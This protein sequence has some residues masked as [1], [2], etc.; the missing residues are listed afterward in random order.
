MIKI[1]VI[2]VT[3]AILAAW[4]KNV[5]SEYA[6]WIVLAAGVFLVLS[7]LLKLDAIID[8][9]RF[10]QGY[11]SE[12][13]SYIKLLIKIIGI[14]YLSEFSSDL[15]KDAGANTLGTQI[16]LFGKLSILVLCMPI[17]TSLLETVDYYLGG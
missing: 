9:L 16:E 17:M 6:L 11:F 13:A 12:Y 7:V 1:A 14:T 15:C 2:G 5:K 8:E 3:A 4:I 10:L